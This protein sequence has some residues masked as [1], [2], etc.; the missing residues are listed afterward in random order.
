[1]KARAVQ[2]VLATAAI[3]ASAVLASAVVP[4]Q[5]MARSEESFD[6]RNII[7][8]EFGEW[9][10]VPNI[11]LV[12]PDPDSLSRV[13]Y[14]QEAGF[15]FRD[16][17]GHLVMLLIAYGP[18]Q[19]SRLQLH[20]PEICYAA[21]GFRVSSVSEATVSYKDDAPPLKVLRLVAQRESRREAI[22]YWMRVGD[23]VAS[24]TYERQAARIRLF[25]NGKIADGALIRVS[26]IGLPDQAAFQVQDRFVHDLMQAIAQENVAFFV[27]EQSP[28]PRV[29]KA[30]AP[31]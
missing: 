2:A 31:Q 5:M 4:R 8:N 19:S 25:L 1:M 26:T 3:L 20:R 11:R 30:N 22:S 24:N 7:P 9:A 12:E 27:G 29:A 13:L 23:T 28:N 17:E 18:N 14:S 15:G 16:R 10:R 6:I 21:S